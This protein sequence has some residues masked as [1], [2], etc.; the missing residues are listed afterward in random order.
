[1]VVRSIVVGQQPD[2]HCQDCYDWPLSDILINSN[3]VFDF[4]LLKLTLSLRYTF[5]RE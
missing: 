3:A 5:Q 2:I 4:S 1:M